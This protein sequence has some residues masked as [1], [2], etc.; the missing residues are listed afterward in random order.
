MRS[1]QVLGK[2]PRRSH[3]LLDDAVESRAFVPKALLTS[4]KGTEV[5][6]SLG[7]GLRDVSACQRV[8]AISEAEA[9]LA[10]ETHNN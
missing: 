7:Y 8:D 4:S 6:D 2:E 10:V 1:A 3:E 9:Y 5:L